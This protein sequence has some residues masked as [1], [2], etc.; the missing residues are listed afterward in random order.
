MNGWLLKFKQKIK[1][2]LDIKEVQGGGGE[3]NNYE[4]RQEK[5]EG[6]GKEERRGITRY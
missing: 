3:N 5:K 6:R 1:I 2:W 4:K